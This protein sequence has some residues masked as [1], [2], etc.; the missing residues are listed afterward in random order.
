MRPETR[1]RPA[2]GRSPRTQARVRSSRGINVTRDYY[3]RRTGKEG[4]PPR[5][6]VPEIGR[7]LTTVYTL[8]EQHGYLQRSFGYHCVDAGTVAGLD[9]TDLR[10]AVYLTTGIKLANGVPEFLSDADEVELFTL[11]EFLHDHI[12]KPVK[13]GYFHDWSNCGWHYDPQAGTFDD[14]GARTEWRGK[15]NA[16]LKFYEDGYQLSA[17]GEIVRIEPDGTSELVRAQL[18]PQVSPTDRAKVAAAVRTFHLGR[19]TREERKQ[20]VRALADVLEFH[21]AAVKE[22]LS[23]DEGDLFNIANNFSI[24]H[25]RAD[26]RDDYDDAWLTWLFYSYLSTVHFVLGRVHGPGPEVPNVEPA[27][28]PAPQTPVEEP[29]NMFGEDDEIPF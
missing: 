12:A 5:L 28:V 19:S 24:R 4:Q 2:R 16:F 7:M 27:K 9:G 22:H 26:Q 25:H 18:S 6:A 21:R 1:A 8:I 14:A 10:D 17:A 23:K 15:I 11:T 13:G 3:N 20:A 29:T